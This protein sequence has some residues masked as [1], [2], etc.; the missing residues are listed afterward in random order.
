M[1]LQEEVIIIKLNHIA[2]Y[3]YDWVTATNLQNRDYVGLNSK[4]FMVYCGVYLIQGG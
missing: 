1:Y 3:I 4:R 2:I